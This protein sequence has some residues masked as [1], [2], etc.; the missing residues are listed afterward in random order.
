M[1]R[2]SGLVG[3]VK[4][5]P[6]KYGPMYSIKLENDDTWYGCKGNK[7]D[8]KEGDTV[9]FNFSVNSRGYSDADVG[10][11]ELLESGP[12]A[13]QAA[14]PD[15]QAPTAGRVSFDKKQ[16]VI[17]YQSSRKDALDLIRLAAEQELL[18]LPKKGT[19]ADKFNA[20]RIFI[21]EAT[22]D[23]YTAAMEVYSTGELPE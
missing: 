2:A 19:V 11:L 22:A 1:P 5:R 15:V 10:S 7:P 16:A 12:D 8:C 18:D 23:Y 13:P 14:A 21:D 20:L 6:G 4:E 9:A 3:V 17:V